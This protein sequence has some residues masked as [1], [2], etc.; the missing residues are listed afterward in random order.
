MRRNKNNDKLKKEGLITSFLKSENRNAER[1]YMKYFNNTNDD[2]NNTNGDTYDGEIRDK[3]S[4]I[5]MILSRLGR[6][7]ASNARKKFKKSF[8]K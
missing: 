5:S 6:T 4:D 7:M 2:N 3:I 8:V 1:N